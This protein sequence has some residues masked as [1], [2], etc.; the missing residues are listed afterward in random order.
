MTIHSDF[1]KIVKE[2]CGHAFTDAQPLAPDVVFID[3]QVK[4]MKADA[5]T[6]WEL[7]YSVQF[8]RTVEKCFALGAH[9]VVLAFDD[10]DHVPSSKAMTQAKRAKMRVDYDFAQTCAL[11]SRPPEDWG[12]AMAN[13]SFKVKVVALVLDATSY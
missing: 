7:F 9:T 8:Y 6:S 1:F 4:L 11:P 3:R 13:R 5:I 10:Y 12:S 2:G